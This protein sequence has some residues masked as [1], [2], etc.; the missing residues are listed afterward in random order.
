M[1][2]RIGVS[3]AEKNDMCVTI[4]G[5]ADYEPQRWDGLNRISLEI[6]GNEH[7]GCSV[8]WDEAII[9]ARALLTAAGAK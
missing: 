5:H 7:A 6:D 4:R 3:D 8:S 9:I 2:V 1:I